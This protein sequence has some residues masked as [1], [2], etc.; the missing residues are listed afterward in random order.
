M[1]TLS[2]AVKIPM[3]RGFFMLGNYAGLF[4]V[5][6]GF[7]FAGL[8]SVLHIANTTCIFTRDGPGLYRLKC[9]GKATKRTQGVNP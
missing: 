8:L 7:A 2:R 5:K 6:R 3:T 9:R 1:L 4:P